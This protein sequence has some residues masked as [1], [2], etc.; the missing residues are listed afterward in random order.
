M[1]KF[2]P[3]LLTSLLV[4]G[5]AA[6]S[7]VERTSAD[8][9]ASTENVGEVPEPDEVQDT[10]EDATSDIRQAQIA[11]DERARQQR[12]AA[13]GDTAEIDEEDV[14][15]LVRNKLETTLPASQLA[16][17]AG[18]DGAVKIA[19]T[20]Q[21]QAEYDQIE[22]LAKEVQGVTAVDMTNVKVAPATPD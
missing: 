12:E 10:A 11:S 7:D 2:I 1:K 13:A 5:A 17:E 8:A 18:E 4:V 16:I 22:P 14:A 20:V 15:S 19:G 9:P 6:C 21:T 3:V